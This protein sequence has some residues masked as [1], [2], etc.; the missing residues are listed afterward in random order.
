GGRR[1][2]GGV[3]DERDV[4]RGVDAGGDVGVVDEGDVGARRVDGAGEV[5]V[6]EEDDAVV[7]PVDA[8]GAVGVVEQGDGAGRVLAGGVGVVAEGE[9][10]AA[11]GQLAAQVGGGVGGGVVEKGAAVGPGVQ[12]PEGGPGDVELQGIHVERGRGDLGL[13]ELDGGLG[14]RPAADREAA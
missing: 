14:V 10:A 13:E 5:A 8:G 3:V 11:H 2:G 1:P 6:V 9:V 12:R 7:R 4:A